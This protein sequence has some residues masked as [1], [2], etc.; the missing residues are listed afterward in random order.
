MQDTQLGLTLPLVVMALTRS[1][2]R[3]HVMVAK[4]RDLYA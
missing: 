1:Y 4:R 3:I 2:V